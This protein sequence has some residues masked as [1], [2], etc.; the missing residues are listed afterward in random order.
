MKSCLKKGL[1]EAEKEKR[2]ATERKNKFVSFEDFEKLKS[3]FEISEQKSNKY[4]LPENLPEERHYIPNISAFKKTRDLIYDFRS[5]TGEELSIVAVSVLKQISI[6]H[7]HILRRKNPAIF[8]R[9]WVNFKFWTKDN[10][11]PEP[12]VQ[13][14]PGWFLKC[15]YQRAAMEKGVGEWRPKDWFERFETCPLKG[16]QWKPIVRLL[17]SLAT[18]TENNKSIEI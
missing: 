14:P 12:P 13:P 18:V 10:Y 11:M 6:R 9:F 1:K 8:N 4:E 16:Q 7:A 17:P 3:K 15:I 5:A 2:P